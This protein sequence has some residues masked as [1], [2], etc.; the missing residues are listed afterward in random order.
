MKRLRALLSGSAGTT[1]VEAIVYIG[2]L[3]GF[4]ASIGTGIHQALRAEPL[5]ADDGYADNELRRG[6]GWIAIDVHQAREATAPTCE[7]LTLTWKDYFADAGV[8]HTVTYAL[9]GDNLVRTYDGTPTVVAHR[10]ESVCFTVGGRAVTADVEVRGKP[11]TTETLS[12][13][14]MMRAVLP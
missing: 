5:I 13:K 3:T 2:L 4:V 1:L 6:L 7:T 11:D 8:D 10:V 9:S 12:V 14:A